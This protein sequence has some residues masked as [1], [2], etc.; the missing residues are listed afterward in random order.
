MRFTRHPFPAMAALALTAC[1]TGHAQAESV[2]AAPGQVLAEY[3]R[4]AGAGANPARGS[5]LLARLEAGATSLEL[6][7]DAPIDHDK[8]ER[9]FSSRCQATLQRSCSALEKADV[10]AWLI[11]EQNNSR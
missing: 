8:L 6:Q 7:L 2:H 4:D 10:A 11:K 5:Q 1:L 9:W 3:T